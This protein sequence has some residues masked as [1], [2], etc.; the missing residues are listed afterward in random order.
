MKLS[1]V[2]DLFNGMRTALMFSVPAM[3]RALLGSPSLLFQ[4]WVLSRVGMAAIWLPFGNGGDENSRDMK[5]ELI[6]SHARGC[7]LD[8]GAAY[9]HT[10]KYLD[11]DTVSKYIA[12]E[13]N[14]FMHARLRETAQAAGFSEDAGTLLILSCGAE[15]IETIRSSLDGP[16]DT[17]VT[18]L[19]LCSVPAPE[20]TIR[21]LVMQVLASGGKLILHEH[22]LN[23]RADVAW[24]QKGLAPLWK[25]VFD[26]CNIDRPTDVWVQELVDDN[27]ESV[28]KEAEIWEPSMDTPSE[29]NLLF[30]M[31]GRFVKK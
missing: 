29:E 11:H 12:L 27:K 3:G 28:W 7:V 26:G 18:I 14:T 4:P 25:V 10:A 20:R 13:P 22:V 15:D 23:P 2:Y 21:E 6:T 8:I 5:T 17:I 9:G 24:W 1:A 31:S 30:R 19:T 16:V